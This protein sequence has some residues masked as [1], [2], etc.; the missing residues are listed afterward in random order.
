MRKTSFWD[1]KTHPNWGLTKFKNQFFGSFQFIS[2]LST[3]S[4]NLSLSYFV[5][6]CVFFFGF[7]YRKYITW[8]C[9]ICKWR[10]EVPVMKRAH[11]Q[12]ASKRTSNEQISH[13][14]GTHAYLKWGGFVRKRQVNVF[15]WRSTSRR[16]QANV[17]HRERSHSQAASKRT[18]KRQANV[19]QKKRSHWQAASQRTSNRPHRWNKYLRWKKPWPCSAREQQVRVASEGATP[20][21]IWSIGRSCNRISCNVANRYSRSLFPFR[22]KSGPTRP[23][24]KARRIYKFL[25]MIRIGI[26]NVKCCT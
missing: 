23:G 22:A 13:A 3:T 25:L 21:K 6:F 16:L 17:P 19:P 24:P 14:S 7:Y 12:A 11:S 2:S 15:K 5:L 26:A 9:F 8:R 18:R 4:A 20:T 10:A 1:F